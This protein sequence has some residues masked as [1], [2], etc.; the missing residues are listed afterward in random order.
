MNPIQPFFALSTDHYYKKVIN[1]YGISHIYGFHCQEPLTNLPDVLPDG[2][3]DIVFDL[4]EEEPAA[5]VCRSV[6]ASETS[7]LVCQS[8]HDYL[9][10][11][12]QP[13]YVP[14]FL[15]GNLS[16]FVDHEVSLKN[17]LSDAALLEKIHAA[18]DSPLSGKS[19]HPGLYAD[20]RRAFFPGGR[21]FRRAESAASITPPYG[22]RY[23][24]TDAGTGHGSG[25]RLQPP[26]YE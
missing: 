7:T 18:A 19:D 14:S 11:R 24:R 13:G 26:L 5:R 12:F 21:C 10:I 2:C 22:Y 1:R 16:D 3:I 9:G 25:N 4:S 15:R 8:G 17:C 23:K 20:R 6:S